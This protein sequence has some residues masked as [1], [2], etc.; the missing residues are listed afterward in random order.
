A[1][2]QYAD[3]FPAQR[4]DLA[5]RHVERARPGAC[6]APD[7]AFRQLQVPPAAEHDLGLADQPLRFVAQ[8]CRAIL[9]DPDDRQPFFGAAHAALLLASPTR[10]GVPPPR[11]AGE[12]W[13]G[14]S[15]R[16]RGGVC[17]NPTVILGLVPRICRRWRVLNGMDRP[18]FA[19]GRLMADPR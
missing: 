4:N 16:R 13:L 17:A 5:H 19:T 6:V 9:A 7:Q 3:L 14:R 12:R 11:E 1:R 10:T 15:P 2:G 18:F 8:P